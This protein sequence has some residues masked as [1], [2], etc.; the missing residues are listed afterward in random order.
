MTHGC[1]QAEACTSITRHYALLKPAA[2]AAVRRRSK[3]IRPCA[4][5]PAARY[6]DAPKETL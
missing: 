3:A 5:C 1:G 2:L 6:L 4:G